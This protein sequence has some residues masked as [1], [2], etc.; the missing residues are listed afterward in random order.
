MDH[1]A[2]FFDVRRLLLAD[3]YCVHQGGP[4]DGVELAG[5][6]WFTWLAPGMSDTETGPTCTDESQAWQAAVEHRLENSEIPVCG[7][8]A[9]PVQSSM[10]AFH[11]ARLP[12]EALDADALA[13]QH[14][15]SRDAAV[16]QVEH[17]RRQAVY[18]NDR[19]QVNVQGIAAPFGADTSDVFWLSIK[20]RDRESIH[21]WRD[22]QA[23][24]NMIVGE[25]HEGFEVYPAESRLVDTANQF[26]LWVFADAAVRLPVGFREREVTGAPE[27]AAVGAKQRD[28]GAPSAGPR[29]RGK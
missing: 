15:I 27:A 4:D 20:R 6:Y 23:I 29:R 18:M 25:E 12:E 28:F 19:Y 22:L 16:K 8:S 2:F 17:L 1:D 7:Q 9:P 5:M 21:D 3:G 14:G 24:K 26:H 13:R 10:A 11:P